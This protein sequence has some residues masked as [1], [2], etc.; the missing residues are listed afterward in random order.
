M[1]LEETVSWLDESQQGQLLI[2]DLGRDVLDVMNKSFGNIYNWIKQCGEVSWSND[3][4]IVIPYKR[5]LCTY[6]D[7]S[8]TRLVFYA[9]EN[10]LRMEI[11]PRHFRYI[12]LVF[13]KRQPF[14]GDGKINIF[15]QI[16]TIDH[17]MDKLRSRTYD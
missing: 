12:E 4:V 3:F 8:L 16:P 17:M 14:S 13:H 11:N 7:S 10:N 15:R 5:G 2:S 6:D 9:F 1:N